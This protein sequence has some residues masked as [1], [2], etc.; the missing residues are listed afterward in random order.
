MA[1]IYGQAI[2]LYMESCGDG[3][4]ASAR[5]VVQTG[6]RRQ[7]FGEPM[8]MNAREKIVVHDYFE[9]N[10]AHRPDW[11]PQV[12]DTIQVQAAMGDKD[13][14]RFFAFVGIEDGE[15]ALANTPALFAS[16]LA[17]NA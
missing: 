16:D 9:N 4:K 7:V 5:Y 14:N 2:I 11:M 13:A 10:G 1:N 15:P 12:L 8:K 17:D 6:S 3:V